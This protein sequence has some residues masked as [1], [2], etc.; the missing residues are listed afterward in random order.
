MYVAD[1]LIADQKGGILRQ[2][3]RRRTARNPRIE[4][5]P[6]L[7]EEYRTRYPGCIDFFII[8]YTSGVNAIASFVANACRRGLQRRRPRRSAILDRDQSKDDRLRSRRV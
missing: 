5:R 2:Y 4:R 1:G 3:S 6:T 8:T 7:R